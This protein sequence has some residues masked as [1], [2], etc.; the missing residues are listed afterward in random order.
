M[1]IQAGSKRSRG[2]AILM[3]LF[4]CARLF[5]MPPSTA[6]AADFSA[7]DL[8]FFER[9]VRPVLVDRCF[10]CHSH[11][12]EKLKAGLYLDSLEGLL[13]GGDTKIVLVPGQ[14]EKS[15]LITAVRYTDQEL[16]MPPKGRLPEQ[17]ISDLTEWVR[18]G[19]PWPKE[20]AP[21][22]TNQTTKGSFDLSK[23]R[24]SHWA[25]RPIQRPTPPAI[26]N[27]AWARHAV[28]CFIAGKVDKLGLSQANEAER[29]VLVRRLSLDLIGLPPTPEEVVAYQTDPDPLAYEHLVDSLLASPHFGERWARHWLDLVRFAETLG[30]EFDYTRHNAW[31]YRDYVIRALNADVPYDLFVREQIAGDLIQPPRLHPADSSN[32]SLIGTAFY[33][34]G[35]QVHSP[36]DIRVHQAD[37]IDNQIDVFSKTFL[38]LT[39]ACARCHDHKFDAISTRDFYSL[40]GVFSSSR[41]SQSPIDSPD[42][43]SK[44]LL[45]LRDVRSRLQI[46]VARA[47]EQA[48][49]KLP[50]SFGLANP[51]DPKPNPTLGTSPAHLAVARWRKLLNAASSS[52]V[53]SPISALFDIKIPPATSYLM[54]ENDARSPISMTRGLEWFVTGWKMKDVRAL[55]GDF[56]AGTPARPIKSIVTTSSFHSGL[57][58]KRLQGTLR[59]PTFVIQSNF[60][61]VL[62]AGKD[63][64]MNVVVDNFTM[65]QAPIY[66]ALRQVFDSETPRWISI[67][68]TMWKGHRAYLELADTSPGDPGGGGRPSYGQAGFFVLK[69][70][71]FSDASSPPPPQNSRPR[72]QFHEV[73]DGTGNAPGAR[74]AKAL[75]EVIQRWSKTMTDGGPQDEASMELLEWALQN[76]L[77]EIDLESQTGLEIGRMIRDYQ[78]L[79]QKLNAPAYT[80]AMAEGNGLNEAVFIRGNPKTPGPMVPRRFLEGL[81]NPG[82]P[83]FSG[84]SGRLELAQ[85][86]LDPHNPFTPRV[87]ANRIWAHLFGRGIVAS[88]DDFGALGQPPSNPEL[89]DWLADYFRADARWSVKSLI[90]LLVTSSSYRMASDYTSARAKEIDPDNIL[91]HRMPV[92]RVEA[93]IIRDSILAISGRLDRTLMGPSV[94]THLTAFMEGRGRPGA[95]GPLDGNGRRSI[96]LE[97]RNNFL[98]PMM[99]TFDA[100]IPFTTVGKRTASNVPAQSLVLMNDPFIREQA[101]LWAGRIARAPG[102]SSEERIQRLFMEACGRSASR[103]EIQQVQAFLAEQAAELGLAPGSEDSSSELWS[104]LCHALLNAKELVYVP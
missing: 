37:M 95:S 87:M 57:L 82:S 45:D 91:L 26:K 56:E 2:A 9:R 90:R 59:S 84:G 73:P 17:Q 27:P 23:R 62:V 10:P 103:L 40:F 12:S 74:L 80:P 46:A 16:Q 50:P 66:G 49:V 64:R 47:W 85:H 11:Q 89:L 92:K 36:V 68:L 13:K 97:V 61:H 6:A 5:E 86:V 33:W 29:G 65:I 1:P 55:P 79:E 31:R 44:I 98:A 3:I 34:F 8:D 93:E 70:I 42:I 51:S 52:D 77:L 19:A 53:P 99:R 104:D 67:N 63:S 4:A 54:P 94:P 101:T 71:E 18:R 22:N 60:L 21:T 28:D 100:P 75:S 102:K 7:D 81:D 30:H 88:T 38:G 20:G 15:P 78:N 14:P 32:E 83:S 69:Q 76:E 41:Y 25:W 72:F 43:S 48:I 39:V 35:Q 24:T 58:S 96:Y